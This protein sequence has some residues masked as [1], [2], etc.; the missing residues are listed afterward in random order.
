MGKLEKKIDKLIKSLNKIKQKKQKAKKQNKTKKQGKSDMVA[1]YAK[2]QLLNSIYNKNAYATMTG[3]DKPFTGHS[4][5]NYEAADTKRALEE[6]K[7]NEKVITEQ[8]YRKL[9]KDQNELLRAITGLDAYKHQMEVDAEDAVSPRKMHGTPS[10][11]A[12]PKQMATPSTSQSKEVL[13][14]LK[15]NGL[16]AYHTNSSVRTNLLRSYMENTL[17]MEKGLSDSSMYK[18]IIEASHQ[19]VTLVPHHEESQPGSGASSSYALDVGSTPARFGSRAQTPIASLEPTTEEEKYEAYPIQSHVA[20]RDA[21]NEE[22]AHRQINADEPAI[23]FRPAP[24]PPSSRKAANNFTDLNP[25]A[26]LPSG[27]GRERI[28]SAPLVHAA[29]TQVLPAPRKPTAIVAPKT[30]LKG[31]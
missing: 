4:K 10:T 5:A 17:G 26:I 1:N 3:A 15:L 22:E 19:G 30:G 2:S 21:E 14:I 25:N 20:F 7:G 12:S 28:P 18:R 16:S 13:D 11:A 9:E 23:A 6:L 31:K 24:R 27:R 29:A 8:R